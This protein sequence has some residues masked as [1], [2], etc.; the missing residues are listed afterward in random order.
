M[1]RHESNCNG[2]KIRMHIFYAFTMFNILERIVCLFPTH[3]LFGF[4]SKYDTTS[5]VLV[6]TTILQKSNC[7]GNTLFIGQNLHIMMPQLFV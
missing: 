3:I 5:I 4:Y 2:V 7:F 6:S 1:W